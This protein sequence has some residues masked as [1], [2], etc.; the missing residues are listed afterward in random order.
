MY[1]AFTHI[2]SSRRLLPQNVF[3]KRNIDGNDRCVEGYLRAYVMDTKEILGA[4]LVQKFKGVTTAVEQRYLRELILVVS[5]TNEDMNDAIEM[6]TWT[7]RYDIDGDPQAELRRADGTVMAALRF[8]GMQYL[9][10]QTAELLRMIRALCRDTLAP[11]PTGASAVIRITYTDRTPKGYQAPGF[12]RSPEEPV[13][14]SDAQEI[15]IGSI[16]TKYYG[17]SVVIRS[18]FIDDAYAVGLRLKEA[19]KI[20]SLDD[21]LNDSFG[22]EADASDEANRSNNNDTMERIS[23]TA[24][25]QSGDVEVAR[26]GAE[27]VDETRSRSTPVISD[28]ETSKLTKLSV[29]VDRGSIADM[30]SLDASL[31]TE[32]YPKRSRRGRPAAVKSARGQPVFER[33]RSPVSVSVAAPQIVHVTT[34]TTKPSNDSCD[35]PP[36]KKTPGFIKLLQRSHQQSGGNNKQLAHMLLMRK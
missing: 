34:P 36:A 29:A 27:C 8:R 31:P 15:E 13:L 2:L 10:K 35:T 1:I 11:L 32:E 17:A 9:K 16:Q 3:K 33:S 7:M 28:S 30:D 18:L 23:D 26:E 24:L 21:S 19:I 25:H 14:R 6:Y 20:G 22:E 12:Y 5:P 4:R